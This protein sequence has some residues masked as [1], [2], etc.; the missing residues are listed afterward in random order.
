MQPAGDDAVSEQAIEI[1][2]V[3][4]HANNTLAAVCSLGG[5]GSVCAIEAIEISNVYNDS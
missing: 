5:R 4:M 2:N 3:F 1:S